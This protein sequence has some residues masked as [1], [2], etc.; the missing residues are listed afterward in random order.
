VVHIHGLEADKRQ[1]IPREDHQIFF[2]SSYG[3]EL[4]LK[5]HTKNSYKTTL[6]DR[7]N[8]LQGLDLHRPSF[9]LSERAPTMHHG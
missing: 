2:K 8:E 9:G 6:V 7:N 4:P 5:L 3:K 1:K